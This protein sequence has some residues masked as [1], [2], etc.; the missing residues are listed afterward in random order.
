M[1]I[2]NLLIT[3]L[4]FVGG[5]FYSIDMLPAHIATFTRFDPLFYEVNGLRHALL[6]ES[7][8]SFALALGSTLV[9]AAAAFGSRC[10]CSRPGGGSRPDERSSIRVPLRARGRRHVTATWRTRCEQSAPHE[11][12]RSRGGSQES[13][14]S[15]SPSPPSPGASSRC[16]QRGAVIARGPPSASR[17][18][19]ETAPDTDPP[20]PSNGTGRGWQSPARRARTVRRVIIALIYLVSSWTS[21]PPCSRSW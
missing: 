6:G 12:G 1:L 21:W 3:P 11:R 19:A 2:S 20:G 7:D 4:L 15:R 5:V 13:R 8:A 10:G 16:R 17:G 18:N 14:G 9:L